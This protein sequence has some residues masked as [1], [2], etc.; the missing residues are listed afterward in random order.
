[1]A[2]GNASGSR[3]TRSWGS[4]FSHTVRALFP[5]ARGLE[6]RRRLRYAALLLLVIAIVVALTRISDPGRSPGS[7]GAHGVRATVTSV[8]LPVAAGFS[9]LETIGGRLL[10]LGGTQESSVVYGYSASLTHGRAVGTCDAAIVDPQTLAIGPVKK[11]N[12][13]DPALYGQ[14]VL[15]VTYFSHHAAPDGGA[16]LAVRIARTDPAARDGYRLGPVVTTYQQC[17]D[18]QAAVIYG[19][20]SLWIYIPTAYPSNGSAVLLRISA[21]TGEVVERW[22]MPRILRALLAVNSR[23]LW[24]SPSIESGLPGGVRRSQLTAYERLYRITPGDRTPRMVL[25]ESKGY[26]RWLLA[27]SDTVSAAIAK[28]RGYSTVWTLTAGQRPVRGPTLSDSPMGAELGTGP[29]TV[30]GNDKLGYYNVVMNNGTESVIEI[31]PDGRHER[32]IANM[33]SPDSTDSYPPVTSVTLDG[34]LFFLDPA[35]NPNQRA[36]LHRVTPS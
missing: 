34:S 14:R 1:M 33:R 15:A 2:I 20:G 19:D 32:P 25:T 21:Q 26:A 8:A 9:S 31:T 11:A 18:C 4:F 13:A 17:S 6:R 24:L 10:V 29:P 28:G 3:R 5:E 22:A 35:T 30:A 7:L 16:M 23:G 12:C 36:D 27:S